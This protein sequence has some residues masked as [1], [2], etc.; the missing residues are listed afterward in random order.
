MRNTATSS[1]HLLARGSLASDSSSQF[2]PPKDVSSGERVDHVIKESDRNFAK[3]SDDSIAS[4]NLLDFKR[5][6]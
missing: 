3:D 5:S 4:L 6:R 2:L 1:K